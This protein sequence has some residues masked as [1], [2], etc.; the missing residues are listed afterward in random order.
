MMRHS[1][2]AVKKETLKIGL[3]LQDRSKKDDSKYSFQNL[4][5]CSV[6][7]R[8]LLNQLPVNPKA[9]AGD[10]NFSDKYIRQMR[11]GD[12]PLSEEVA[13]EIIELAD[14]YTTIYLRWKLEIDMHRQLKNGK[15][16]G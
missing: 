6:F 16:K 14:S 1:Q 13:E 10:L 12:R 8:R 2:N 11:N 9:W 4:G 5:N 7:A 15:L 3:L